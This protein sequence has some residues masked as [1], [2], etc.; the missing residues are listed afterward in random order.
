MVL[1]LYGSAMSTSR[2]LVTIPEKELPYERIFVDIAKGEQKINDFKKLQHFGKVPYPSGKKLIPEDD[3][4]AYARFEE[5]CSIE[6][7]HFVVA[8]ETIGTEFII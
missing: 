4:K 5:A 2:V 6:Q 3:G 7:N 1:K 8:A